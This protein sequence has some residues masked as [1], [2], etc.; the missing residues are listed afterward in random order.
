MQYS[1]HL[2]S[3]ESLVQSSDTYNRQEQC[4][5]GHHHCRV[6]LV[7]VRLSV[8]THAVTYN[9]QTTS[10]CM[11]H[12]PPQQRGVSPCTSHTTSYRLH[13]TWPTDLPLADTSVD[14]LRTSS[15]KHFTFPS[16][17]NEKQ[18]PHLVL[19]QHYKGQGSDNVMRRVYG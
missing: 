3:S 19:Q 13:S 7:H 5:R 1:V 11:P 6:A 15:M 17:S 16:S 8:L 18:S 12:L 10:A 4:T 14:L 2:F 9:L